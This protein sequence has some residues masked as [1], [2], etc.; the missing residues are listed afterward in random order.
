M[1]GKSLTPTHSLTAL[2]GKGH[3]GLFN[4]RMEFCALQ[5]WTGQQE[6]NGPVLSDCSKFQAAIRFCV[7][8]CA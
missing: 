6:G 4:E 1:W 3:I 2:Q 5:A 8:R 7:I